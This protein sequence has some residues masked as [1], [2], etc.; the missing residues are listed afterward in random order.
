MREKQTHIH[1]QLTNEVSRID[2]GGGL[3][4]KK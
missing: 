1:R 4:I 2:D 3:S